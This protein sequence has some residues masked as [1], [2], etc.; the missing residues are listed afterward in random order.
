MTRNNDTQSLVF[1]LAYGCPYQDEEHNCPFSLLRTL[2]F[3]QRVAMLNELPP[4]VIDKYYRLHRD[5][6]ERKE[7]KIR[8]LKNE[9][10][11]ICETNFS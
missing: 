3:G 10:C 4:T 1:G 9:T 8:A 2:P 5:C 7:A 6:A 11:S